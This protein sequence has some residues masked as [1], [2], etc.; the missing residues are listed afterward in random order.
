MQQFQLAFNIDNDD[1]FVSRVGVAQV[2]RTVADN[3]ASGQLN[4]TV[5]S[6]LGGAIGTYAIINME[7]PKEDCVVGDGDGWG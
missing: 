4:G 6:P 7:K 3:V 5:F 2:I 1:H